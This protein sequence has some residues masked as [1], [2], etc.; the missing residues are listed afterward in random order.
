MDIESRHSGWIFAALPDPNTTVM[1]VELKG[2][3]HSLR[4][5][6][7]KVLG[8]LDGASMLVGKRQSPLVMQQKNC[9]AETLKVFRLLTSQVCLLIMTIS[10]LFLCRPLLRYERTKYIQR[11]NFICMLAFCKGMYMN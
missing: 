6:Q 10:F 7:I 4:L 11:H 1:K 5:R 2:P 9:E 8:N 3:D